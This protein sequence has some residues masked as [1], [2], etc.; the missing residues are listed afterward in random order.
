MMSQS[1]L[2]CAPCPAVR[3]GQPRPLALAEGAAAGAATDPS[4]LG[5]ALEPQQR[6]RDEPP[7]QQQQE[8]AAAGEGERRL[9]HPTLR[10]K[11]RDELSADER[12]VVQWME[13]AG[14]R[15]GE[16]GKEGAPRRSRK[17]KQAYSE[18]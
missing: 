17:L 9:G 16:D 14:Q 2:A 11:Q 10:Q 7:R 6:K 4:Q 18:C 1:I 8:Q 13:V 5:W 15:G 12:A 3:G